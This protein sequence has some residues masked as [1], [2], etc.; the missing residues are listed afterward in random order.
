MYVLLLVMIPPELSSL[1]LAVVS[2]FD[3]AIFICQRFLLEL[4]IFIVYTL[5][6]EGREWKREIDILITDPAM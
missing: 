6:D 5:L 4:L 3:L 2:P 1:K